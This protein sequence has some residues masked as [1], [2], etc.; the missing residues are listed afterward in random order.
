MSTRPAKRA[1]LDSSI[2]PVPQASISKAL[3]RFSKASLCSL[4]AGWISEQ[5][6]NNR[7][8]DDS[9]DDEGV[10]EDRQSY[11]DMRDDSSVKK[12]AVLKRIQR[13]WVSRLRLGS[14]A[15]AVA[16]LCL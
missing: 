7:A 4:A 13:D 12:P 2:C 1:K 3:N 6:T 11:E 15:R 8:Q 10:E 9:D 5:G 14:L 16:D